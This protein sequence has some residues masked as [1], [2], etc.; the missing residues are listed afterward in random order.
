MASLINF[1]GI[2]EPAPLR[3]MH[4]PHALARHAQNYLIAAIN[5]DENDKTHVVIGNLIEHLIP[6]SC[7]AVDCEIPRLRGNDG[8]V[9]VLIHGYSQGKNRNLYL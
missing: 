2:S 3:A 5:F 4:K 8:H 1:E 7:E 9:V 6:E